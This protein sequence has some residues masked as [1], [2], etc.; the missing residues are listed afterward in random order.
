VDPDPDLG[1]PKT[2]GSGS[3]EQQKHFGFNPI[4]GNVSGYGQ[5]KH[6]GFNPIIC[7]VSGY[8]E[9]KHFGF[10]PNIFNVSGF[11]EQKHFGFNPIVCNV[12]SYGEQKHFGYCSGQP[13]GSLAGPGGGPLHHAQRLRPLRQEGGRPPTE[14]GVP[15]HE[16]RENPLHVERLYCK[17]PILCL[18]PSKILTPHCPPPPPP[19]LWWGGGPHSLCGGGGGGINILEDAVFRIRKY[20]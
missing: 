3:A 8:E 7:N 17:R 12:S 1:G 19:P 5:Q 10:N 9:Q 6:F 15:A 16:V 18:A 11:G 20:F 4:I 13:A 14:H 2:C